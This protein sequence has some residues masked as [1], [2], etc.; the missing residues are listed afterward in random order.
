MKAVARSQAALLIVIVVIALAAGGYFYLGRQSI[1]PTQSTSTAVSVPYNQ[2]I[3]VDETGVGEPTGLDPAYSIDA[4]AYEVEQNMYQGLIWF[5]GNG[6]TDYVGVLATKWTMSPDGLTYTFSL[7][8]NVVFNNGRPFNA[9]AVWF[10]FYRLALN[11]G[12]PGYILGP[13]S[14][15]G[16]WWPSSVTLDDLNTFN[17]QSPT[18]QQLAVMQNPNQP[19]QV[20]DPYTIIFHLQQ[21]LPSFISRLGLSGAGAIV[22][23]TFVQDHGGVQANSTAN[24]YVGENGAPGT[25]PYMLD[26]WVHGQSITLKLNPYF[27]GPTPHVSKVIIQYKSNTLDAINDIKT[28]TVQMLYT[29]P[30]NLLPS[31][32]GTPGVVLESHGLS[33]D[34]SWIYLTTTHYPLNITNVRLAINYAINKQSIIDNV[35]HGYGVTFQGPVPMGMFGYNSSIEP[36]GYDPTMAKQLLASAGFPGGVGIKPLTFIY[37]TGDPLVQAAVQ[38]IQSDLAQV[39][40]TVNLQGVTR[41]T[42]YNIQSIR[43]LVSNYPDMLWGVWFPDYPYPD[44]YAYAVENGNALYT[45]SLLNDTLMNKWTNDAQF[46]PDRAVQQKL[47]SQIQQREKELSDNVWLWQNKVGYGV[48]AYR[49]SVQSVYWNPMRFGFNYSGI[50][51]QPA[52]SSQIAGTISAYLPP[53]A[54]SLKDSEVSNGPSNLPR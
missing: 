30:Y 4:S 47:Y 40:I 11:N 15:G 48:P 13:V 10:S 9:Y 17:F 16:P 43:P 34:I 38:A 45:N 37:Y 26:S 36:I 33:Y 35:L 52:A 23:P 41:Q 27:S 18:V 29:I 54:I 20:A 14:S 46:S 39:G 12:P 49:D 22:D 28:G 2:T 44:D 21:P 19:I 53:Q 50:Y 3:V 51:I 42:Y 1:L 25:G 24:E 32:Q 5:S 8:N 6:T 31:I 7:R